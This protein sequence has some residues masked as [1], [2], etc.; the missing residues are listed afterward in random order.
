MPDLKLS[1]EE[2]RLRQGQELREIITLSALGPVSSVPGYSLE[3]ASKEGR[4]LSEKP[5]SQEKLK[6]PFSRAFFRI[7][8]LLCRDVNVLELSVH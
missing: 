1:N 2:K 6:C 3:D 8:E 7:A 5:F 4:C